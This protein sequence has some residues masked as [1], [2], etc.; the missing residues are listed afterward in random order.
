MICGLLFSIWILVAT[1][2]LAQTTGPAP[3]GEAKAV[4]ARAI[5]EAEHPCPKVVTATRNSD[6]SISA[7]CSNKEDYR[8]FTLNG[9]VLV[10]RCS[11]ARKL[12]VEGC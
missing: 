1:T 11:E 2:A 5:A 10:M 4:A 8:V 9:K 3:A 6:G 12:G 7:V